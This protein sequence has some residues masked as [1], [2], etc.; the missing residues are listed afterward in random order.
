LRDKVRNGGAAECGLSPVRA[1]AWQCLASGIQQL[2]STPFQGSTPRRW[3][4][5]RKWLRQ[6]Q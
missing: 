5:A 1:K 2:F 6:S 4:A 3:Q